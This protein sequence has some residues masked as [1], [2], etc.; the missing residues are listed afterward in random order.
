MKHDARP[1]IPSL[2][3]ALKTDSSPLVR[4]Y[5]IHALASISETELDKEVVEAWIEARKDKDP[6][7]S[8]WAGVELTNAHHRLLLRQW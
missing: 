2:L 5:A 6:R 1:A 3:H 4:E 8:A 7:V